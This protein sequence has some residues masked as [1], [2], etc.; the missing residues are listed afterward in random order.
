MDE[1]NIVD[2][3]VA[4][5]HNAG[6]APLSSDDMQLGHR[7]GVRD[8]AVR[9]GVYSVFCDKLDASADQVEEPKAGPF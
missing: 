7:D 8:V 4:A 5:Y 1:D 9:L 3:L 6:K 2:A